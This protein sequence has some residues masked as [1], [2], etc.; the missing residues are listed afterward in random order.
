MDLKAKIT[1]LAGQSIHNPSQFL[2]DVVTSNRNLSKITVILDGVEH[3]TQPFTL[4]VTPS[5]N[6]QPQ[7]F[8]QQGKGNPAATEDGNQGQLT[9]ELITKGGRQQVWVGE[10]APVRIRAWIPEGGSMRL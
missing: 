6:Q 10:I 4:K 7:G 5:A 1:E 3:K 8:G 9:V 2:V